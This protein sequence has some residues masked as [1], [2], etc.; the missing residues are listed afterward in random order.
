MYKNGELTLMD[1]DEHKRYMDEFKLE[2]IMADK[3]FSE[4]IK[5]Q[6][7]ERKREDLK[8]RSVE[9][10]ISIQSFDESMFKEIKRRVSDGKKPKP[11]VVDGVELSDSVLEGVR[12][13]I[14]GLSKHLSIDDKVQVVTAILDDLNKTIGGK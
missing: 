2:P 7:E 11:K 5:K 9:S 14:I 3:E 13:T 12:K 10:C 8:N 1:K 4:K 6:I